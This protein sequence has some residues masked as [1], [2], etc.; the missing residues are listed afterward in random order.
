MN[1]NEAHTGYAV[2]NEPLS[3][4]MFYVRPEEL[5]DLA[6]SRGLPCFCDVAINDQEC[7]REVLDFHCRWGAF[8]DGFFT[9]SAFASVFSKLIYRRA[10]G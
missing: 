8:H 4:R 3:Y 5:L 9:E 6:V 10:S 2:G 1:P 7:A